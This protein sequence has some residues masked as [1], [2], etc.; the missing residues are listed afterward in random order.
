MKRLL[1][2]LL[3]AS[4]GAFAS[5]EAAQ[6]G[7][8]PEIVKKWINFA[9]LAGGLGY[10]AVKYGGP[11]MRA[12][13]KQILDSIHGAARRAQDAE[14]KAAEIDRKVAG[15][16]SEID[17]LREQ[18]RAEMRAETARFEEDALVQLDKIRRQAEND[19]AAARAEAIEDLKAR[20][21]R[22]ALDLAKQKVEARMTPETQSRLVA[23]FAAVLDE[24]KN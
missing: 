18:A 17:A 5:A 22:L 3:L 21:A 7:G 6:H 8:V 16:E 4:A 13:Q 2:I 11:A 23:Q 12:H 24:R 19:I 10:L 9:I 1:P 14:A 15:L 20:A